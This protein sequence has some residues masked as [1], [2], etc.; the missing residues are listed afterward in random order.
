MERRKL[1]LIAIAALILIAV[2]MSAPPSLLEK[3]KLDHGTAESSKVESS[4]INSLLAEELGSG[5]DDDL[6]VIV[7]LK[8]QEAPNLDGLNVRYSYHLIKGIAG[9]ASASAIKRLANDDAVDGIYLD[10]SVHAAQPSGD[11]ESGALVSPAETVEAKKLWDQGIDGTGVIVAILDS[12]IDKNHPDLAGKVV[13][14]KNFVE[15]E[16]TTDDLL[17]H[18]TMVAGIIAGSGAASGGKYKGVAPG[19]SLLNARVIDSSGNGQVSDIIA[20]IEWALDNDADIISLSLAGLNLGETNP[21]VTMAADNAMD[22]GAVVCVAAGN[23]G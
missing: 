23:N 1:V 21:P 12:G 9:D 2:A 16:E 5:K 6:P 3:A 7:I 22:A 4:K 17:G 13:G 11:N 15:D 10:S 8:G 18:G 20:G 19:A 14:E